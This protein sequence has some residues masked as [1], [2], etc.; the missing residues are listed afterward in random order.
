M[1]LNHFILHFVFVFLVLVRTTVRSYSIIEPSTY[2]PK[3]VPR[4]FKDARQALQYDYF[5]K[6]PAR[7]SNAQPTRKFTW[8]NFGTPEI[9]YNF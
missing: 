5:Q 3:V 6:V 2:E 8:E 7:K 9:H 4:N 1:H